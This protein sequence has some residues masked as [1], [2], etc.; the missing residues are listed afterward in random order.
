MSA[1]VSAA[2]FPEIRWKGHWIWVLDDF[3]PLHTR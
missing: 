1:S 2:D 3:P